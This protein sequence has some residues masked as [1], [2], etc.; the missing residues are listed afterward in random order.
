MIHD[1][2]YG[3]I[4][5][6]NDIM[7][8][9]ILKNDVMDYIIVYQFLVLLW[10][11]KKLLL[12]IHDIIHDIIIY[13]VISYMISQTQLQNTFLALPQ[14]DCCQDIVLISCKSTL[15][16]VT[17]YHWNFHM[18]LHMI[19]LTYDISALW[20]VQFHDIFNIIIILALVMA[21]AQRDGAGRG[22][23]GSGAPRLPVSPSPMIWEL[24]VDRLDPECGLVAVEAARVKRS[25]QW[26]VV[27]KILL[28]AAVQVVSTT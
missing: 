5:K 4:T 25:C 19:S 18:V 15:I 9:I 10:Y 26:V 6:K 12:K 2:M 21:P 23:H 7:I 17:S 11:H 16:S 14:Y 22:R 1:I 20:Y 27:E 13:F 28:T 8:G 24:N 3:I